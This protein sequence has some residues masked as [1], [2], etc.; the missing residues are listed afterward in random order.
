MKVCHFTLGSVNPSSSNGINKVLLGVNK[1]LSLK[2]VEVEVVTVRTKNKTNKEV[3][4]REGFDVI[5]FKKL[6]LAIE[7]IRSTSKADIYHLHNV[8]CK[9]NVYIAKLLSAMNK[10]YVI[11][12]HSGLSLD[13]IKGSHYLKKMIFHELFQKKSLDGASALHALCHEEASEISKFTK[14]DSFRIIPNGIAKGALDEISPKRDI[15]KSIITFGFIG[16]LAEEKNIISLIESISDFPKTEIK[17]IKLKLI[18]SYDSNYGDQVVRL[19]ESKSLTNTIELCGALYGNELKR[20]RD[21]IDVYTHVSLSEGSSLSIIEALAQGKL[22]I[23]SRTSNVSYFYDS[24]SFL[25]C[26][27]LP[28]DIINSMLKAINIIDKGDVAIYSQNAKELIRRKFIWRE[29]ASEY[30]GLYESIRPI[31]G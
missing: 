7:Y 24:R 3:F 16:R 4:N 8:W 22:C 29:I 10:P 9:E 13:R 19:I 11:S 21:E 28:F 20:A 18:G 12:F 5:A 31:E 2:G 14:N 15:E 27:P 6:S 30:I 1:E 25:M 26:E 17:R 23:L